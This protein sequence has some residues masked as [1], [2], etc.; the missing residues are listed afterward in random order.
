MTVLNATSLTRIAIAS[1]AAFLI[2]TA[3]LI[4]TPRSASAA[5]CVGANSHNTMVISAGITPMVIDEVRLS[6]CRAKKLAE[7]YSDYATV[8]G[9]VAGFASLVPGLS[10]KAAAGF[11]TAQGASWFRNAQEIES[12]SKNFKKAV[13]IEF[14]NG[15]VISCS[16]Q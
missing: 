1:V 12:C 8:A 13:D 5:S 7:E 14:V 11:I 6:N 10:G 15:G 9:F 4:A 3:T 2:A 16:T